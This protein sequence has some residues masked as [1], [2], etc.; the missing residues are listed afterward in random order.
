MDPLD[1]TALAD[2]LC[3]LFSEGELRSFVRL[4]G[5][6]LEPRLPGQGASRRDLCH[7]AAAL[8]EPHL[9]GAFFDRLAGAMPRR[10]A[11]IRCVRRRFVSERPPFRPVARGD[12]ARVN[13]A[14]CEVVSDRVVTDFLGRLALRDPPGPDPD[15]TRRWRALLV[16]L[17]HRHPRGAAVALETAWDVTGGGAAFEPFLVQE[18][19]ETP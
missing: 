4:T 1:Q 18:A 6:E 9:D 15:P 13:A 12:H 17:E 2:L 11:D 10:E 19:G 3:D 8:L 5:R 16:H 14:L 7:A